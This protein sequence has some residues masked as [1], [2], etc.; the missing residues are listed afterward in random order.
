MDPATPGAGWTAVGL[1]LQTVSRYSECSVTKSSDRLPALSGTAKKLSRV[2]SC[3]DYVAGNWRNHIV[4]S[5]LW[6]MTFSGRPQQI[7][8]RQLSWSWSSHDGPIEYT[9]FPPG[10]PQR[11]REENDD[12]STGN[13][14]TNDVS[15][16]NLTFPIAKLLDVK[17]TLSGSNK[18]GEVKDGWLD[19]YAPILRIRAKEFNAINSLLQRRAEL[20]RKEIWEHSRLRD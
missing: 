6:A 8:D 4:V 14:H 2:E 7:M 5:L 17:V 16:H 13:E 1:W 10:S 9:I 11:I 20:R 18:F 19:L 3:G 12:E 15:A